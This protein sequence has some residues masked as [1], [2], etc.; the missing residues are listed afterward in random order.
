M[1]DRKLDPC[2]QKVV[3]YINYGVDSTLRREPLTKPTNLILREYSRYATL[4]GDKLVVFSLKEGDDLTEFRER[5]PSLNLIRE[6][7]ISTGNV[8]AQEGAVREGA[9]SRGNPIGVIIEGE[10]PNHQH[11]ITLIIPEGINP[12]KALE[13]IKECARQAQAASLA[14]V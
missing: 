9:K 10:G 8:E 11:I 7:V 6:Q 4:V 1:I 12:R 3:D 13:E 14:I 2:E 5:I